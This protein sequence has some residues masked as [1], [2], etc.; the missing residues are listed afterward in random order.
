MGAL[1]SL[2]SRSQST[3]K[4]QQNC[5]KTPTMNTNERNKKKERKCARKDGRENIFGGEELKA[6]ERT[7]FKERR[8]QWIR[9]V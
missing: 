5:S 6:D 9:V 1:S 3:E 7:A 8:M 4:Q 2:K